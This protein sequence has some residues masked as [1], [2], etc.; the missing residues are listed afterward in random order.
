M[1]L[2]IEISEQAYKK[3]RTE[4][5]TTIMIHGPDADI[6]SKALSMMF[7]AWDEGEIPNIRS[8]DDK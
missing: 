4:V 6:K 3:L 5:F 1:K 7:E 2:E 8:K